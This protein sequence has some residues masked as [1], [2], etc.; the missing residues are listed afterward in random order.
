LNANYLFGPFV[1]PTPSWQLSRSLQAVQ[2]E[3]SEYLLQQAKKDL[4]LPQLDV[5]MLAQTGEP[6]P[7]ICQVAQQQQSH[8]IIIGSD[9]TR[10]SLLAPLQNL[11]KAKPAAIKLENRRPLRNTRLSAT[12]DYTIHHAPCPV[13]LC[14]T[15]WHKENS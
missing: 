5:Q 2:K 13:L 7:L 14:R 3:Q 15:H 10:R 9:A 4:N 11:R 1:T 12:E 6:G 8:L